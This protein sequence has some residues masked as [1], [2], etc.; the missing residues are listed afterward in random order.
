MTIKTRSLTILT[1]T[2][3]AFTQKCGGSVL[4]MNSFASMCSRRQT[5]GGIMSATT[6]TL[7]EASSVSIFL[8]PVLPN[9][10]AII[11]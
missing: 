3:L 7:V 1:L 6:F 9:P 8:E 10:S 2:S 11:V 5:M 4:V